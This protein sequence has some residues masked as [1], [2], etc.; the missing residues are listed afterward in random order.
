MK[1][2]R[3]LTTSI[4]CILLVVEI[5]FLSFCRKINYISTASGKMFYYALYVLCL[6]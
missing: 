1:S 2:I 4:K 6:H 3:N 5:V